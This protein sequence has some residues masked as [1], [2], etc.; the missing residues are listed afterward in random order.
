MSIS[1]TVKRLD[2]LKNL[3]FCPSCGSGIHRRASEYFCPECSLVFPFSGPVPSMFFQPPEGDALT[4]T[5][6]GFY[7]KNPFPDYEEFDDLAGLMEKAGKG[8]FARLLDEQIPFGSRVLEC[9]CGTGQ[10]SNFLGIA[11]RSVIGTDIALNSLQIADNFRSKH[12]LDRVY[13]L[14][15]NLFHPLFR[16]NSFDL[17]I[18][19]GVLHHTARPREGFNRL[20]R[21]VRPGGFFIVGLYHRWGRIFTDIR[22]TLYT[23]SGNRGKML[24]PRL[25]KAGLGTSRSSAWFADQ[26]KNPHESKHTIGE[27]LKWLDESGLSFMKSIPSPRFLS[28]FT[29]EAR[30]FEPDPYPNRFELLCKELSMALTDDQEGGFFTM[31][32]KKNE[33]Q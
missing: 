7:N 10:L 22:R 29:E 16:D 14:Q 4:G 5:I 8:I 25:R 28:P 13:F 26:Y 15:M 20:S 3:I 30:L 12:S 24:D 6:Q 21:L 23:I 18:C 27:V 33:K 9:G 32:M 17:V 2:R 19:N 1:E 11:H 31:I